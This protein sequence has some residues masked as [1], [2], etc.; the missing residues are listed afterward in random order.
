MKH[1]RKCKTMILEGEPFT[2]IKYPYAFDNQTGDIYNLR[3]M[4]RLKPFFKD[5]RKKYYQVTIFGKN[6]EVHKIIA[7]YLRGGQSD[8]FIVH[9]VNGNSLDNRPK[10]LLLLSIP[11]H[12]ELHR[13]LKNKQIEKYYSIID[14]IVNDPNYLFTIPIAGNEYYYLVNK[15]GNIV[16]EKWER[17]AEWE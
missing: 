10:N 9:H 15:D 14:K 1:E 7:L 17:T 2:V 12:R 8:F 6:E 5:H 11:K 16:S 4:K 13:L 3:T